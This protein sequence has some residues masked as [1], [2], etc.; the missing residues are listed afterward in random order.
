MTSTLP[1][2]TLTAAGWAFQTGNILQ[3]GT[4][5]IS[6]PLSIRIICST[7][8]QA[9]GNC[10]KFCTKHAEW[11]CFSKTETHAHTHTYTQTDTKSPARQNQ[12]S[13]SENSLQGL[14]VF[15]SSI[16]KQ[17][18]FSF[19]S[20]RRIYT[21]RLA[22]IVLDHSAQEQMESF[23]EQLLS[24]SLLLWSKI[25]WCFNLILLCVYWFY[26]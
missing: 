24:Y 3:L 22:K 26:C 2:V 8:L 5:S 11:A 9:K 19:C 16:A 25:I 14:F 12:D 18:K 13:V 10:C 17:N 6:S 21:H 15:C 20:Q 23:L 4:I 1:K 7:V